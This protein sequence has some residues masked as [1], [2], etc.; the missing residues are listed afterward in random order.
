MADT[1]GRFGGKMKKKSTVG[2]KG[3]VASKGDNQWGGGVGAWG[4]GL[5]DAG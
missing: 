5:V 2:G 1:K 3:C 4:G